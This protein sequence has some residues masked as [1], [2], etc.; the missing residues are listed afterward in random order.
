MRPEACRALDDV[1]I[2]RATIAELQADDGASS[3]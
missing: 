1:A 2:V 3:P